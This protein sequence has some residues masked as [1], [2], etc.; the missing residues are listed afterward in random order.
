MVLRCAIWPAVITELITGTIYS[1]HGPVNFHSPKR[2][3]RELITTTPN[4]KVNIAII[5]TTILTISRRGRDLDKAAGAVVAVVM[6]TQARNAGRRRRPRRMAPRTTA[7]TQPSGTRAHDCRQNQPQTRARV[8]RS[9]IQTSGIP[10]APSWSRS[11]IRSLGCTSRRCRST[12]PT[13][14]PCSGG[15]RRIGGVDARTSRSKSTNGA[16][17]STSPSTALPRRR[18]T[19]LRRC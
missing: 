5:I 7:D 18:R 10:T 19:T 13:L 3:V 1:T 4:N 2:A 14:P 9:P 8:H 16:R 12:R 17:T 11:R 15:A 6:P